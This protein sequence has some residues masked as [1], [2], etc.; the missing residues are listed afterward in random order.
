MEASVYV[1]VSDLGQLLVSHTEFLCVLGPSISAIS[2]GKGCVGT[3]V[4][5]LA[6]PFCSLQ[7][8]LQYILK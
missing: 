4:L 6:G 3:S 2:M 7:M 5:S 8:L 1:S